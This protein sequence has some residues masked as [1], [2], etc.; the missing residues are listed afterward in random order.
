MQ[1]R[2]AVIAADLLYYPLSGETSDRRVRSIGLE[3]ASSPPPTALQCSI[4]ATRCSIEILVLF[5]FADGM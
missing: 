5:H 1:I 4:N 2:R 3:L